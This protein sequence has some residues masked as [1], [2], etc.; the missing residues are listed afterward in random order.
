MENNIEVNLL[1]RKRDSSDLV[2][3]N[4]GFCSNILVK[5]RRL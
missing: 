3:A 2:Y 5:F 1:V 4:G